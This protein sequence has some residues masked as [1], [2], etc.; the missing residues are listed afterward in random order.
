MDSKPKNANFELGN[1]YFCLVIERDF[2]PYKPLKMTEMLMNFGKTQWPQNWDFRGRHKHF[3]CPKNNVFWSALKTKILKTWIKAWNR[4]IFIFSVVLKT[5]FFGENFITY[6]R[7]KNK[8]FT[9]TWKR[10]SVG[11]WKH[12]RECLREPKL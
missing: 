5:I 7:V 3:S 12:F 10:Q 11:N 8:H 9:F 1:T 2:S 4:A 6:L